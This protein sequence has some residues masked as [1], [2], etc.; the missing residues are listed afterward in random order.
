[1]LPILTIAVKVV[2]SAVTNYLI[3]WLIICL[4]GVG[5]AFSRAHGE[6]RTPIRV[7]VMLE[8]R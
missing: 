6:A 1:M 2:F 7:I 5:S 3:A 4:L 8:F